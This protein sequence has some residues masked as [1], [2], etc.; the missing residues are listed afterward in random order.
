MPLLRRQHADLP[1]RLCPV[2]DAVPA[3][4]RR[5]ERV[6]RRGRGRELAVRPGVRL[7]MGLGVRLDKGLG[8]GLDG[9]SGDGG[10]DG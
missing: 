3:V 9:G 7:D 5:G 6:A 10:R 1:R 8:M 4:A 2:R